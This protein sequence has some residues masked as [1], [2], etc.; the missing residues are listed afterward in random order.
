MAGGGWG[1]DGLGWQRAKESWY[2]G[3]VFFKKCLKRE[4]GMKE[5]SGTQEGTWGM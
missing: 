1:P 4:G 3:K 5:E 2:K